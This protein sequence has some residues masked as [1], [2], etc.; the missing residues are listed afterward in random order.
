MSELIKH[1][2]IDEFHLFVNPTALGRGLSIFSE[3]T[4]LELIRSTPYSSGIVVN[5]YKPRK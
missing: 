1:G 5:Q 2:L 4:S 3:R